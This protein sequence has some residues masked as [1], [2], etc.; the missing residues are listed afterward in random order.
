M[1][2][3]AKSILTTLLCILTV[4]LL[5]SCGKGYGKVDQGRAIEY[6]REKG[7]ITLIRDLKTDPGNPEYSHLPAVIYS[8]P[9]NQADIGAEPKTG[10]RL[11]LDTKKSQIKIFDPGTGQFRTIDYKLIKQLD[12]IEKDS[13]LVFDKASGKT[14]EFPVIDKEAKT[15]TTYSGRQKILT[16]FS[17]ADEYLSLPAKTWEAGDD[18]RIEY[19]EDGKALKFANL[20]RTDSYRK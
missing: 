8:L 12:G 1:V 11:K 20:T 17:V 19:K 13:P 4:V 2:M 16:T 9:K 14:R 15:I 6:D 10:Y 7:T 3:N 18:V 5:T